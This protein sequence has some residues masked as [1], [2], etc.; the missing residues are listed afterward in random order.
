METVARI[1]HPDDLNRSRT[2]EIYIALE[3][4]YVFTV[5]DLDVAAPCY[6][7][8]L[9]CLEKAQSPEHPIRRDMININFPQYF[10]YERS[11]DL[12]IMR[13]KIE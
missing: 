10:S 12:V 2:K 8:F 11:N 13:L 3:K 6:E 4:R 1:L 7:Y 5:A 9:Q